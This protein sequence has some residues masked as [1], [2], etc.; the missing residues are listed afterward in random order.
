MTYITFGKIIDRTI[1]IL[2]AK[3]TMVDLGYVGICI[4]MQFACRDYYASSNEVLHFFRGSSGS[5][6]TCS[7]ATYWFPLN[8]YGLNQRILHLLLLKDPSMD[9][10]VTK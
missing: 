3:E 8:E 2:C 1:E 7:D 10:G 4:V 5:T 6:V 9:F